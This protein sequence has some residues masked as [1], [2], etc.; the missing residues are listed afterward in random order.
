MSSV[1]L[2]TA[3]KYHTRIGLQLVMKLT[4]TQLADGHA[5]L[6]EVS[7]VAL[8]RLQEQLSI[9][10]E[11]RS[12]TEGHLLTGQGFRLVFSFG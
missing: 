11:A 7:L 10:C 1:A 9:F 5:G 3:L 4:L 12:W 8:D 2:V 6:Q